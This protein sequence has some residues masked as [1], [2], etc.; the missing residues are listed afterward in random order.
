MRK[1]ADR[2]G[3]R[4][5]PEGA[6]RCGSPARYRIVGGEGNWRSRSRPL[7]Y[8]RAQAGFAKLEGVDYDFEFWARKYEITMGRACKNC[9]ADVGAVAGP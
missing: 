4:A 9:I 8:P 1:D 3:R 5:P 2:A 6:Q 7:P